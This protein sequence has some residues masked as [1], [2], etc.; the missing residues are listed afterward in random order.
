M[1]IR[2]SLFLASLFAVGALLAADSKTP[3]PTESEIIAKLR[4]DY[5][6]KT[7]VVT[8]D[9]LSPDAIDFVYR[10]TGKPDR[11]VRFCCDGCIDD[12]KAEPAKFLKKIDDAAAK[13]PAPSV[14]AAKKKS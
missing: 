3:A 8:G 1:K 4:P 6:L 9:D 14:P 2:F 13:A 12:F 10:V 5:P 7:C 11:L